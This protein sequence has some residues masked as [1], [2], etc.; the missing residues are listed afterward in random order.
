[1]C[2]V[3]PDPARSEN[4]SERLERYQA[5]SQ[6]PLDVFALLTLWVV[7]VPVRSFGVGD[8]A[9]LLGLMARLSVSVVFA[10]D[11]AIRCHLAPRSWRYLITH[12]LALLAVFL[13]PI[14]VV[15]SLRLIR[16]LFQRG[17]IQRFLV[18]ASLLLLDGALIVYFYE[19]DAPGANIV[20]IGNSLWWAIVTVTTVGY[21][22]LYPVTLAGRIVASGVMAIGVLTLA[23]VT[24]QVS[25]AFV[26]QVRKGDQADPGGDDDR[27]APAV[28][29]GGEVD[30]RVRLDRLEAML[31]QALSSTSSSSGADEDTSGD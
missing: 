24:A 19:R 15:F 18:A 6:T 4:T 5:R 16:S 8:D 14:R 31:E 7:V 22:D 11:L 25:S 2:A 17:Q 28:P 3:S 9:T 20:T 26:E 29:D 30:L 21:G 10:I 1:M 12:P 23:V 27:A 13:P